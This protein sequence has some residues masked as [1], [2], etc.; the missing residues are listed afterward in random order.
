MIEKVGIQRVGVVPVGVSQVAETRRA[1]VP[2]YN[3][4]NSYVTIPSRLYHRIEFDFFVEDIQSEATK[5]ID[6]NNP[7]LDLK[8]S[9][10]RIVS[11]EG[12]VVVNGSGDTYIVGQTNHVVI[13]SDTK[14]LSAERLGA[15]T[16]KLLNLEGKLYNLRLIDLDDPSNS[17]YYPST[18]RSESMPTTT[19]LEDLNSPNTLLPI[20]SSGSEYVSVQIEGDTI[21]CTRLRETDGGKAQATIVRHLTERCLIKVTNSTGL[22]SNAFLYVRIA[23]GG[24]LNVLEDGEY[25]VDPYDS[26][27][28]L[29]M[30][31]RESSEQGDEVAFT[32]DVQEV[33]HG[34]LVNFGTEQS[35]VELEK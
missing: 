21:R 10:N 35:W 24:F 13:T 14:N 29:I 28:G 34:Q 12:E 7:R 3:G 4:V 8:F 25:L 18:I 1:W 33:T 5:L 30:S 31:F 27:T 16:D 15:R 22:S 19:V 11:N 26:V 23:S 9:Q 20:N 17:R 6:G 2:N 32:M